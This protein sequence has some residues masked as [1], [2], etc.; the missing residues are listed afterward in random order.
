MD[1]ALLAE[2]RRCIAKHCRPIAKQPDK[3][4]QN[5]IRICWFR[6]NHEEAMRRFSGQDVLLDLDRYLRLAE[7]EIQKFRDSHP[8]AFATVIHRMPR[9]FSDHSGSYPVAVK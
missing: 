4:R 9:A 3:L 8:K 5:A 7:A 6:E 2:L 1:E